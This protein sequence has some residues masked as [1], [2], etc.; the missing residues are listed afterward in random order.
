MVGLLSKC[1]LLATPGSFLPGSQA[2]GEGRYGKEG[3]EAVTMLFFVFVV[4]I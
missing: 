3:S 1:D 4:V 2:W